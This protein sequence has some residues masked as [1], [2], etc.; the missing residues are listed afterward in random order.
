MRNYPKCN[1]S[2]QHLENSWRKTYRCETTLMPLIRAG[3]KKKK[4][5]RKPYAVWRVPNP[6]KLPVIK[7][8][9]SIATN[10][11]WPLS[12][13]TFAP[14]SYTQIKV[15]LK[16]ANSFLE[17]WRTEASLPFSA[18][19]SAFCQTSIWSGNSADA[20][21]NASREI[22]TFWLPSESVNNDSGVGKKFKK[23]AK[24]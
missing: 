18:P 12:L 6:W 17:K 3:W 1:S 5:Q 24:V 19:G 16:E 21:W 10:G 15:N 7:A 4:K 8:F 2:Q 11:S 13:R 14:D 9:A 22:W 23:S 20:T